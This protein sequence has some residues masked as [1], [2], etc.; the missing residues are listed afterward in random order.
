[1]C[2]YGTSILLS[3]VHPEY[4]YG[5]VGVLYVHKYSTDHGAVTMNLAKYCTS[6]AEVHVPT[7]HTRRRIVLENLSG[8]L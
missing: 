6:A 1:M 7:K 8:R 2:M 5:G 4:M 3:G